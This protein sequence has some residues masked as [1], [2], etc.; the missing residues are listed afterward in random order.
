ML[1]KEAIVTKDRVNSMI[2]NLRNICHQNIVIL[3]WKE[4]IR[5]D[6]D[7]KALSLDC[8]EHILHLTATTTQIM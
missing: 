6:R 2:D 7:H 1:Y 4:Y 8:L 5:C 3:R